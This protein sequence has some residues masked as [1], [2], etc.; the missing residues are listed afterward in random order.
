[1]KKILLSTVLFAILFFVGSCQSM[2]NFTY[3]QN[4]DSIS[5]APSKG[6]PET[7]IVPNDELTIIVKTTNPEAAEPFNLFTSNSSYS[8]YNN[9][10]SGYLVNND[11][12][13]NFP[14]LGRIHVSGLTRPEVEDTI[15]KMLKPYLSKTEK[16]VVIC[17]LKSFHVTMIGELGS[18]VLD[19]PNEK[20]NIVEAIAQSGDLTTYGKRTNIL[21]VRE[22]ST[23]E[24]HIHRYDMTKGQIFNDPYYYLKQNDIVYVE[25]TKQ[26]TVQSSTGQWTTLWVTVLGWATTVATLILS[27]VK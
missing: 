16:P 9:N 13:I 4:I 22:D 18:K 20:L 11:G 21:L 7:K 24:K 17:R 27:I 10:I 1:M 23:G 19:A 3:F 25:P 5:L 8:N 15:A 2:R 26:K 14:V 12:T 6:L